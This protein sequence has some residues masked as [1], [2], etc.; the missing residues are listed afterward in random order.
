MDKKKILYVTSELSPYFVDTKISEA[1]LGAAKKMQEAG[2]DVR[3]FIPKFGVI[4]ERRHQLHEVIRL[5]GM[6]IVINDIDQPL[7][8]KV[9]SVPGARLQA[10]FID[11]EEYFER[12][13]VYC[14]EGSHEVCPDTDERIMFFARGVLEAVRKLNWS[15]DIIHIQ[16]W[17]GALVPLYIKTLYKNDPIFSG[18]KVVYSVF[19]DGFDGVLNTE[20]NKKIVLDG[21]KIASLSIIKEPNFINLNKMAVHYSDGVVLGEEFIDSALLETVGAEKQLDFQTLESSDNAYLQFYKD[22]ILV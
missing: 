6:N 1:S 20:M 2:H 5:S 14:K 18:S 17:F 21:I 19:N 3:V 10:Y 11:N 22:Q 12:K 13:S 15:P 4:N 8:I 7:I 16:G 9:A